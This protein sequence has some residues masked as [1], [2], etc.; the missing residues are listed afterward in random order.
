MNTHATWTAYSRIELAHVVG[1]QANK[2]FRVF[3]RVSNDAQEG[4]NHASDMTFI[5]HD[6]R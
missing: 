3:H 2:Q 5:L 6:S 1:S 4:I